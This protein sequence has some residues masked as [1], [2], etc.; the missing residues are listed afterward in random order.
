M[1]LNQSQIQKLSQELKLTPQQILQST[2]LQ[3]TTLSLE[4]RIMKEIEQNPVL[5]EDESAKDK[6]EEVEEKEEDIDWDDILPQNDDF[7]PK[8][9]YDYSKEE[10]SFVQPSITGFI[11]ELMDQLKLLNLSD[12][13]N[14]IARE[15]IWNLDEK[16]YLTLPV[17]NIALTLSESIEK[18]ETVLKQVQ[19]FDPLG[20]AARDLR[21][22]LLIQ[23]KNGENTSRDA[24]IVI[25]D[26]F[27]DFANRRFEKIIRHLGWTKER[28]SRAQEA[29]VKLNPKPGNA[30]DDQDSGYITPDLIVRK[31]DGKFLV[32]VNDSR[33]P[34]LRLNS[35]YLQMLNAKK[36]V[37]KNTKNYLKK[38]VDMAN[39]FIQ[40]IHQRRITMIRVME[41]IIERQKEFFED[42]SAPLKPMILKDIAEDVNMDISTISRVSNGKYVQLYSGVYELK[43]FFNE[44]MMDSDGNEVSTRII[45]KTLK[46][47]VDG[48]DKT[49]PFSDEYLSERLEKAGYPVA[50]RT[51]AKYRKQL[52]IPVARLRKEI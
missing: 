35:S 40:A 19:T 36:G 52:N 1:Q 26:H 22:C 25:R 48:E 47:I 2:I 9:E 12:N 31:L 33:V 34:E 5:E 41:A 37:D 21:E 24:L 20:I 8:Q 15:I 28:L 16:G 39:W 32:E 44:G 43:Y 6:E 10:R 42:N 14:R 38:K 11:D 45:K 46:E 27:D 50:R 49:K 7:R 29:I 51:I 13:E 3:L 17:E 4:A 18:V 23:L 30:I